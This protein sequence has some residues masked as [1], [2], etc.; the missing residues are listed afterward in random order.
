MFPM[1]VL[2][3]I[4]DNRT[5]KLSDTPI[6]LQNF[7]NVKLLRAKKSR[8][9]FI[10]KISNLS[11]DSIKLFTKEEA[12]RNKF[13]KYQIFNLSSDKNQIFTN[14]LHAF[15]PRGYKYINI[16]GNRNGSECLRV[17]ARRFSHF[18]LAL[19]GY[20]VAISSTGNP[21]CSQMLSSIK[22]NLTLFRCS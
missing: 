2:L 3:Y 12:C 8:H 5:I 18:R 22:P 14:S 17:R 11:S 6:L 13:L 16:F 9:A 10:C 21:S 20:T 15:N 7:R 19:T 1:F 4:S